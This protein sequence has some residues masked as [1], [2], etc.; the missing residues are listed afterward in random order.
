MIKEV[1]G[2][3]V[4]EMRFDKEARDVSF[5]NKKVIN[6]IDGEKTSYTKCTSKLRVYILCFYTNPFNN[7]Y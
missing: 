7:L 2:A 6:L 3:K 5:S 1:I 4:L